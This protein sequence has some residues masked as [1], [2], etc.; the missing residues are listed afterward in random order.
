MTGQR[1]SF[2]YLKKALLLILILSVMAG[3]SLA[4]ILFHADPATAIFH[5]GKDNDR[6]CMIAEIY[7]DGELLQTIPLSTI[8]KTYTLT[9][10]G[11][12]GAVNQV[13]IRPGSIGICSASCPDKLCVKQGFIADSLIPITCLPNHLV[14][15]VRIDSRDEIYDT[16]SY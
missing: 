3:G 12:N 14:I 9:I 16:I 5:S 6:H 13:E 8:E 11:D 1:S 10:T 2:T 4:W 7:R 15:R